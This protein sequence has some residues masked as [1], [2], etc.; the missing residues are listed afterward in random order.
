[1]PPGRASRRQIDAMLI[2]S[3]WLIQDDKPLNLSAGHGIALRE[4][5]LKSGRRDYLLLVEHVLFRPRIQ[6]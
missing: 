6:P 1:M 3:G 2:A 4:V 5:T